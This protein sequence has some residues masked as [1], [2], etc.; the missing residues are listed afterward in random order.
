MTD[1]APPLIPAFIETARLIL[2]PPAPT[3]A[4]AVT[5]HLSD[6]DINGNL[7]RPPLPYTLPDAEAWIT[8][9]AERR[10]NDEGYVYAIT[11]RTDPDTLIGAIGV[12]PEPPHARAEFG[13][14]LAREHWGAGITTE[15][16]A[17]LLPIAFA[18]LPLERIHAGH[19][20]W[21]PASGRVLLR[22]GFKFEGIQR[23]HIFRHG[24]RGDLHLYGLLR[25][26]YTPP[27]P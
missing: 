16:A 23:S 20:H 1:A 5:L 8:S 2:R 22:L 3:D 24:R 27:A 15:A 18:N 19:Y 17:A 4:P 25:S 7:L 10:T 6:P 12:H 13:Y 26:E 21:N 14:W 11:L 9:S